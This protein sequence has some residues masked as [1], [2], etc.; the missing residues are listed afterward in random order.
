LLRLADGAAL[1]YTI[2]GSDVDCQL[3]RM[4]GRQVVATM[5]KQD[6]KTKQVRG[7]GALGPCSDR[8]GPRA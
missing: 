6:D 7:G 4:S 1:D 5:A 8:F 3:I 2:A